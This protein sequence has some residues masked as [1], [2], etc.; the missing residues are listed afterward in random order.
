MF[1]LGIIKYFSLI[2]RFTKFLNQAFPEQSGK[3]AYIRS[4]FL[5]S[6][7]ISLF[8]YWFRPFGLA[9]IDMYAPVVC[10]GFG[11]ICFVICLLFRSGMQWVGIDIF[12]KSW[13]LWKWTLATITLTAFIGLANYIYIALLSGEIPTFYVAC[14]IVYSTML[15]GV[16]PTFFIGA[17]KVN[18][19]IVTNR[20]LSETIK[21]IFKEEH[22]KLEFCNASG[23]SVLIINSQDF[24][25][26]ES[27]Q[28]YIDLFYKKHSSDEKMTIRNTMSSLSDQI[29]NDHIVR[30]HRSYIINLDKVIGVG[31]NAQGLKLFI[32]DSDE[33]IPVSRTFIPLIQ[34]KMA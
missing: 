25:Y 10:L 19:N 18:K 23:E 6:L 21:P 9:Y 17:L 16:L 34:E 13:V 2:D 29:C 7:F 28:N 27:Q 33:Y 32:D 3:K 20:I 5:I 31:G 26:A 22:S 8:L 15:L 11:V 1:T 12:G 30:C 14:R 4:I 24:Y